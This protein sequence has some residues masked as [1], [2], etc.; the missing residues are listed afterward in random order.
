MSQSL[1]PVIEAGTDIS[2]KVKV[3]CPS[4]CDLRG[5]PVTVMAA[6]AVVMMSELA[7]YDEKI[8][9]TEDFRLEAPA[10]VGEYVWSVLFPRH[11]TETVVHEKSCL[12][13]AFRTKPHGTSMAVW[14]APSPVVMNESFKVK[15]GIKCSASCQ[16]T[17]H[18][19]EIRNE[20]GNKIGEGA[21]GET[22]WPGTGSLYW[23][24]VALTAPAAEEVPSWTV[25]F[26]A[27]ELALPHEATSATFTF[28]TAQPSE[29]RVTIRII[30]NETGGPI[31]DVEVRLG[32]YEVFTDERGL[33]TVEVP[34]GTYDLTM[35]KDGYEAQPI[36]L[37]VR[38][39]V[40]IQVEA[41]TAPTK[42]EIEEKMMRFEDYPWGEY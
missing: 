10:Q 24:E 28:R 39:D 8:N 12:P 41:L 38:K 32:V 18:L 20:A 25:V 13:I 40:T 16:L 6:D 26:A 21:L 23:A 36:T 4:G 22:A 29:N 27:A 31:E 3:W 42:A 30:A 11:E 1:A 33:T 34:K 35:R 15:V 2:L 17:G 9:E 37:E 5:I 7:T 14:D 19:V